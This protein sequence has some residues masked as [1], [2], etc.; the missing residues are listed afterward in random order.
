MLQ[1]NGAAVVIGVLQNKD[2]GTMFY[3]NL[4]AAAGCGVATQIKMATVL[5]LLKIFEGKQH[6]LH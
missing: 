4:I 5:Y 1:E 2:F 3:Q 6:T